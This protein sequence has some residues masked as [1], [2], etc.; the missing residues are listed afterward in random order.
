[1]INQ[2][3]HGDCFE[4]LKDIPDNYFD[5]LIT[6]PPAGIS[7]MN[8][9]FDH[10][11][12]GMLNWINWLSEIMA[13][14]LRVMKPGACGLVWSLPRTSHW[15]GMA[16]ELAGF[17]IIDIVH[18]CNGCLSEDTEIYVK[19]KGWVLYHE[20][21]TGDTVIGYNIGNNS[22]SYQNVT[23][24]YRFDYSDTAYRIESD[25]TDQ[26]VSIGHRCIVEQD[27]AFV[28]REAST[29]E[30][31]VSVPF[32]ERM[33]ELPNTVSDSRC[34][35]GKEKHSLFGELCK[36]TDCKSQDR[37]ASSSL[38]LPRVSDRVLPKNKSINSEV[39]FSNV[40]GESQKER[41]E[42]VRTS[43]KYCQQRTAGLDRKESGILLNQYEQREQSSMERRC[44][45]IQEER[46]LQEC[47]VCSMS[48]GIP[49]NGSERRLCD[50]TSTNSGS[51]DRALLTEDGSSS[52]CQPRPSRQP[53]RE[54]NAFPE[55][56]GSQAVRTRESGCK[57]TL[58]T[59]TPF[60]YEGVVWCVSVP[61]TAFVARRNGK[62]FVT[63]NSG[64]P[65][66]QDA[67]KLIDEIFNAE[68]EVV[69]LKTRPDGTQ[70]PNSANWKKDI[71]FTELSSRNKYIETAPATPEAKQWDGWKTPALK[72]SVENWWLVQKP[73]SESSI[74]RN[75]LK[76]GVGGLNIEA[77]RIESKDINQNEQYFYQGDNGNSMGAASLRLRRSGGGA[78][79]PSGRYPANLIL[80]CGANCK[81]DEHSPDCPVTVIGGQS[82]ICTS[83]EKASIDKVTMGTCYR[84]R[85][86]GNI[87]HFPKSVGT[88]AR[89]FKQLP[90]DPET[91]PSV[92]YQ[93][94][95][96][97]SDRS[98]NGTIKN[99]HPTV[100]SRH[101]M[102]YLITLITPDNGIV[103]DPFC[104]SGTTA[105]ACKELGRNYICIEKEKEY[106]NIA[107][108]RVN[109][110]REYSEIE[111]ETREL[112]Q[113]EFKQLSLF[114]IA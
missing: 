63:G 40:C 80:S 28:F 69:G 45:N 92:Y 7:F 102:K 93:A 68:R 29:L 18:H 88:A 39:L 36:T 108:D 55:Q 70:R 78:G 65:K 22:F 90:F 34:F 91:I 27:G 10:N 23:Q 79:S 54:S 43:K 112:K 21:E 6:D 106:F 72:P 64:F 109:Q 19:G 31:Q 98:S 12:G 9:E 46:E 25:S 35:P 66:G 107:C 89:Y 32:L 96:S 113:P 15:T 33:P 14:C 73:I 60:H 3:I 74:A 103:L 53:D 13:E 48:K 99:T 76:H 81:G 49:S 52:S 59:V 24:T 41:P 62:I 51:K 111:L 114:D 57:T 82:G 84:Q 50:G 101:L 83:G 87:N 42:D 97:P 4:V 56:Q 71:Y 30:Q 58:A 38:Y 95:A 67:S 86:K 104:G 44:D 20:C 110:P 85:Q 47:S 61:D 75:I 77:C 26:I 2:I 11:K 37:E 5:S 94:K 100:K 105:I 8:K 17:K 1:M 16:L